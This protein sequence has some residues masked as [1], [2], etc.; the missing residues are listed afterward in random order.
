MN[1]MVTRWEDEE[2]NRQVQYSVDYNIESDNIQIVEITPRQVDF[3]DGK[4]SIGVHT[5]SG[6]SHL[7]AKIKAAGQMDSVK[8]LIAEKEGIFS[9]I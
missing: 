7:T 4:N 5:A 2:N 3:K 1:S 8:Q 6:K 9:A